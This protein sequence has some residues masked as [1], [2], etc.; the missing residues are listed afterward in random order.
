MPHAL[1][2]GNSRK[3]EQPFTTEDLQLTQNQNKFVLYLKHNKAEGTTPGATFFIVGL[4]DEIP[5]WEDGILFLNTEDYLCSE[6]ANWSCS[7]AD[8]Y[9]HRKPVT[10]QQ[11]KRLKAASNWL[12]VGADDVVI[13]GL[14]ATFTNRSKPPLRLL[15]L[16]VL[17]LMMMMTMIPWM[18]MTMM[19]TMM[20]RVM[21]MR[22]HNHLYLSNRSKLTHAVVQRALAILDH[23]E[24]IKFVADFRHTDSETRPK[25]TKTWKQRQSN[26]K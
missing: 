8:G 18:M 7:L 3:N 26:R 5:A 10:K 20:Y 11:Q 4:I 25:S 6:D 12:Q 14:F 17:W 13:L 21:I 23:Y 2:L 1:C 15:S 16:L 24:D 22:R 19:M 9:F